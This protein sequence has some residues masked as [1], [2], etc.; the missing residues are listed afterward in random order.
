MIV[1][2]HMKGKNNVS[3]FYLKCTLLSFAFTD[4]TGKEYNRRK[5]KG[6]LS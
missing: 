3:S 4:K 5:G 6:S 2:H 1:I